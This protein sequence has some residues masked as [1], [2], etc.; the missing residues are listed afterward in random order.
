MIDEGK[1]EAASFYVLDLL[2]AEEREAFT[3][4]MEADPELRRYVRELKDSLHMPARNL[5]AS[6]AREDLRSEIHRRLPGKAA[7]SVVGERTPAP[8]GFPWAAVW[9]AAA[10]FLLAV[11]LFLLRAL[12]DSSTENALARGERTEGGISAG[13]DSV[14]AE[15]PREELVARIQRL[16]SELEEREAGLRSA[17]SELRE[18][19][20]RNDAL[21]SR[22]FDWMHEYSRLAARLRPFFQGGEGISRFTVIEMMDSE[23]VARNRSRRGFA[24]L[25]GRFLTGEENIAGANMENFFGPVVAGAGLQSP[26][27]IEEDAALTPFARRNE[28]L[29]SGQEPAGETTQD[30]SADASAEKEV[31]SEAE[32][33]VPFDGEAAGF[34][35]WRDDEQKGF[36]DVYNLPSPSEG[37]EAHLWVRSSELEPYLPVGEVPPLEE[38]SGSFFYSVDE[39]NFTPSEILITEEAEGSSSEV[40]SGSVLLRGP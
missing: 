4:E 31:P 29:V 20:E 13:N 12:S 25:A 18:V 28:G 24:D 23:A 26:G 17:Q 19:R 11:N 22:S 33:E 3:A 36:L 5:Q 16:R 9:A 21:V 1:E 35:V 40:P 15:L 38:G 10:I 37:K 39:P 27:E 32:E 6:P 7:A 34:T 14:E 30:P 8:R 2:S